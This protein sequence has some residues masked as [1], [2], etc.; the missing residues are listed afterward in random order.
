MKRAL[1][2]LP[3]VLLSG[4]LSSAQRQDI[5]DAAQTSYNAAGALPASPEKSAIMVLQVEIG[6]TIGT[7]IDPKGGD[8]LATVQ[9]V[10][11]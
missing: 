11:P 3:I 4:C 7:P 1:I 9:G 5:A 8:P 6:K 10:T 2:L